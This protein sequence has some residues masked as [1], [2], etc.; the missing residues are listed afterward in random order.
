MRLHIFPEIV[1]HLPK[2]GVFETEIRAIVV[3]HCSELH[4]LV[5]KLGENVQNFEIWNQ[6]L[7]IFVFNFVGDIDLPD[8]FE[9]ID[10]A[11][12][13]FIQ[14]WQITQICILVFTLDVLDKF[15][16]IEISTVTQDKSQKFV[17]FVIGVD[18][19]DQ[20]TAVYHIFEF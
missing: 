16:Q 4:L 3:K 17:G 15:D 14:N 20:D 1:N 12:P 19:A 11:Y 10:A 18:L 9:H 7:N 2:H 13:D 6:L 5:Q 8:N